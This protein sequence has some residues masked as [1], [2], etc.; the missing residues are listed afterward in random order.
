MTKE[1]LR[2]IIIEDLSAGLMHFELDDSIVDRNIDRAL[3]TQ[4]ITLIMSQIK[5]LILQ[6]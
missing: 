6:G 5:Q 2:Q 4:T 1:E 3:L